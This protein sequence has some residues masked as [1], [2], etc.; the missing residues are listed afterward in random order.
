MGLFRFFLGLEENLSSI[1][2]IFRILPSGVSLYI[3]FEAFYIVRLSK[4]HQNCKILSLEG[5]FLG[6]REKNLQ[7][8]SK[9]QEKK[10][11]F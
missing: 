1:L 4:D 9:K 2:A 11:F 3:E 8:S 5:S 7:K 6:L 10:R